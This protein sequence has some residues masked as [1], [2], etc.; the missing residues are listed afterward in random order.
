MTE[1]P[2]GIDEIL[3]G[4]ELVVVSHLHTDHFDDVAKQVV[5]SNCR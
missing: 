5:P 3:R 4:V 2:L 1:L